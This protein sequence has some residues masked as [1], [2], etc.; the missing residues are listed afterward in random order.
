[1]NE[2]ILGR[3][4]EWLAEANNHP[5]ITEP[6]AMFLAT[7][8]KN[9]PTGRVVLLKNVDHRGLAFFT[10]R[11]STKGQ[12]LTE[13]PAAEICFYWMPLKR[14]L[15]VAGKI[16]E[17]SAEEADAYFAT[18][19]RDSQIGAWASDQ[20]KELASRDVLMKRVNE[21][22]ARF[23]DGPVTRPEHW[24]GYRIIPH[25]IEFWQEAPHRLHDRDVYM[26]EG[27]GWKLMKVNP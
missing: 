18:R 11:N 22:T 1:M 16:E 5:Q 2:V 3:I 8:G 7:S 12:N 27:D 6:T 20:S 25:R 17:V 26:R 13:N 24:T 23:G 9:G 21:E 14:Q 4:A 19:S 10:N 15:R